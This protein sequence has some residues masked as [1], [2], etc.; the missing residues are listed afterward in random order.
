MTNHE[1]PVATTRTMAVTLEDGSEAQRPYSLR[2]G[3]E[4]VE[5]QMPIA[6]PGEVAVFVDGKWLMRRSP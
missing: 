3:V 2:R 1:T 6:Y 4:G 5:A